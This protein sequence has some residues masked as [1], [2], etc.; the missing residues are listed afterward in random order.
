ML[1]GARAELRRTVRSFP[2]ASAAASRISTDGLGRHGRSSLRTPATRCQQMGTMWSS[3]DDDAI[4][5]SAISRRSN[6]RY[7]PMTSPPAGLRRGS[8]YAD[9]MRR[10]K[11]RGPTGTAYYLTKI[12]VTGALLAAGWTGFVLG[13]SWWQV[14][15]ATFLAVIFTH[16]GFI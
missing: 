12:A 6:P 15:V 10:V 13:D 3:G 7:P 14:G 16:V 1:A 5:D 4:S 9:L 8:D 11:I 2:V